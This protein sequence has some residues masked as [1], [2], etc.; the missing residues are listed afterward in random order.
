MQEV[1]SP[2]EAKVR[3]LNNRIAECERRIHELQDLCDRA[4]EYLVAGEVVAA[5]RLLLTNGKR[6]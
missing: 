5:E 1:I 3:R 6:P 4:Y 2:H